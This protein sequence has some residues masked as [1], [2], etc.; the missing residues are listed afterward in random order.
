MIVPTRWA[1]MI[2][3]ALV[4]SRASAA[5]SRASVA[6]SSA[7]KL[8]SKTKTLGAADERSRDREPL[9]LAAGD[10]R[11]ALGD[12][13]VELA[14]HLLDE[15]ARLRDLERLP[16]LV[17]GRVLVAEAQVARDGAAEQERLLGH[18][19]DA[20]PEVVAVHVADVDAV[21]RARLPPSRRRSAG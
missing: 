18:E 17:V 21:E 8:S 3:V 19:A 15:V 12:R 4:S 10:V 14:L 11:A 2:T 1:T 13:R 9:A 16:E 20:A 5:R 7:E 6:K